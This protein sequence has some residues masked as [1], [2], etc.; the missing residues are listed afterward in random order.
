MPPGSL[1]SV[2][3]RY[4]SI[5]SRTLYRG[6]T[7]AQVTG[8]KGHPKHGSTGRGS[9]AC[10]VYWALA[11]VYGRGPKA[12]GGYLGHGPYNEPGRNRDCLALHPGVQWPGCPVQPPRHTQT[13]VAWKGSGPSEVDLRVPRGL[14]WSKGQSASLGR[15]A[16]VR[17]GLQSAHT[18]PLRQTGPG[19]AGA[20]TPRAVALR[21]GPWLRELPL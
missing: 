4:Y 2:H 19:V 6:E 10:S 9:S 13:S 20:L 17:G 1:W 5:Q 21:S 3:R 12:P 8:C 14:V 11:S 18:A 15:P 7:M 16:P